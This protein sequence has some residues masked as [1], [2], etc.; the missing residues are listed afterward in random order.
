[1]RTNVRNY[2]SSILFFCY[3]ADINKLISE[4]ITKEW[5][6]PWLNSNKSQ[7]AFADHH[8]IEESI[9]R[10]IKSTEEYRIPVETLYKICQSRNIT[11]SEFFKLVKK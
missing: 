10:K 2:S 7:R 1:M 6:T 5:L 9:V 4:Y 8:N 3:M 11:L